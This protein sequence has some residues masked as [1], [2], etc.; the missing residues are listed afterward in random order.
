V[1]SRPASRLS[2]RERA[3][4]LAVAALLTA[5]VFLP[6]GLLLTGVLAASTPMVVVAISSPLAAWMLFEHLVERPVGRRGERLAAIADPERSWAEDAFA[7]LERWDRYLPEDLG[8][9]ATRGTRPF[10]WE[11]D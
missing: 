10:D 1:P 5:A 11:Q 9:W 2:R 4:V 8:G 7:F 6:A 3:F